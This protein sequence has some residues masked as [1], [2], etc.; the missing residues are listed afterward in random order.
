MTMS[1]H[2]THR[3]IPDIF[4][5]LIGQMTGLLRT[6]AQL[7]R[8]EVSEKIS[9]AVSG[10]GFIIAGAVLMI[11]ALVVL[12]DAAVAALTAQGI[13][14]HWSALIVGGGV[15]LLGLI[16]LLIGRSRMKADELMPN[17]TIEQLQ[18]DAEV[19]KNQMTRDQNDTFQ[20]AA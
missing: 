14:A 4:V 1:T 18:R 11:P 17:R 7:A 8:T 20:R 9:Q 3:S 19:A 13:A 5:D 16:L 12:L 10:L 2:S 6:E 15:L